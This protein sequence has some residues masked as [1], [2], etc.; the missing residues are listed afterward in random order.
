MEKIYTF[1]EST[2]GGV[3]KTISVKE[4]DL[5]EKQLDLITGELV[6]SFNKAPL[7]VRNRFMRLIINEWTTTASEK[8]MKLLY[9]LIRGKN[10]REFD[11]ALNTLF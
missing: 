4:S 10:N 8:K 6:N 3:A 2:E 11:D 9:D 5:T 7:E 1:Y